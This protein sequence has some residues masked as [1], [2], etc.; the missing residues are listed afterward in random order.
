MSASIQTAACGRLEQDRRIAELTPGSM[1]F[2]DSTR[3]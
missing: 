2:Y 1:A 3:P